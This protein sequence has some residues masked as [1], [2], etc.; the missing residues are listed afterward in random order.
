MP[1]IE[2]P[3]EQIDYWLKTEVGL[4]AEEIELSF[5]TEQDKR[6]FYT[7]SAK[8]LTAKLPSDS[9]D[10]D[11]S[12]KLQAH[13]KQMLLQ[14]DDLK[15]NKKEAIAK[16]KADRHQ[17]LQKKVPENARV[18]LEEFMKEEAELNRLLKESSEE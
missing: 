7:E 6:T 5:K 2:I 1:N 11:D 18:S 4:N 3:I 12:F 8:A 17:R 10:P 9:E 13:H 16:I 14:L 15:K